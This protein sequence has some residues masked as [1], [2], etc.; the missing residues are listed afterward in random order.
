MRGSTTLALPLFQF[1]IRYRRT[2]LGPFWLMVGPALFVGGL[3][4][5]LA[6]IGGVPPPLF[7]PHLASGFILWSLIG[8]VIVGSATVFVRGHAQIMQ[9]EQTLHE[10]VV[11]DVVTH[12]IAFFH[13]LPV[14][15][16][17][18]LIYDVPLS[19]NV[20]TSVVGLAFMIA[21]GVWVT[22]VFGILGARYRDFGEVLDAVMRIA[23]LATP[24]IWMPGDSA[25]GGVMDAFL[26]YNPF[27][28]YLEVVRGPLIGNPVASL[29][30]VVVIVITAIGFAIAQVM[31]RRYA[32]YVPL[33]V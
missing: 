23:F 18:L 30:W 14:L 1:L 12:A 31:M 5:L 22:Q 33:W 2:A 28:H 29:S 17:V 27:S 26:L 32:R 3:G 11:A 19:L 8:A 25:R 15:I 10:I 13:Q 16:V 7:M 21:N 20:L 6:E 4:L 24:I 9:G